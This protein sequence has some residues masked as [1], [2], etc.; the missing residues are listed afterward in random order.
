LLEDLKEYIYKRAASIDKQ[1]TEKPNTEDTLSP[2][3]SLSGDN[4]ESG[5]SSGVSFVK[6]FAPW[7]GHCKRL[8]PTWEELA[9]KFSDNPDVRIIKID[10]TLDENKN[11]CSSEEVHFACSV[12]LQV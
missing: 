10:C 3:V 7:C 2:V 8:A 4:F 12:A 9:A 6:F 1:Q 5:I 11:L